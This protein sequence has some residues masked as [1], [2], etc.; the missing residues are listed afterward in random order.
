MI[1][2]LEKVR[3]YYVMRWYCHGAIWELVMYYKYNNRYN[4]TPICPKCKQKG[5]TYYEMTND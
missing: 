5:K 3:Q 1:T 2:E 4:Y